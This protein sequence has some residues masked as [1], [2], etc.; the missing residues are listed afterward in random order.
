MT[1][2]D[3]YALLSE[4]FGAMLEACFQE[5]M[6]P[7]FLSVMVSLR[8]T[9]GVQRWHRISPQ[10]W[11][12]QRRGYQLGSSDGEQFPINILITDST[13]MGVHYWI[14]NPHDAPTRH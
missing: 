1:D 3:F 7:P 10:A 8:G 9:V 14:K 2:E 6:A 13:G 12:F 11:K 5:G 4:M